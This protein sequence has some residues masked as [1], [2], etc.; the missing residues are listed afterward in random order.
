MMF[1]MPNNDG[2]GMDGA[3]PRMDRAS[4]GAVGRSVVREAIVLAHT[5][6]GAELRLVTDR[7]ELAV[8]RGHDHDVS[9]CDLRQAFLVGTAPGRR[10]CFPAVRD[11]RLGG[12][13]ADV[14]GGLF[15]AW[16]PDLSSVHR[17]FVTSLFPGDIV[18]LAEDWG[19]DGDLPD[20]VV[21]A[22]VAT[23]AAFGLSSVRLSAADGDRRGLLDHVSRRFVE[24]CI[25][26]ELVQHVS[27]EQIPRFS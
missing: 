14:G 22:D 4:R 6:P 25:A 20:D 8:G 2:D 26:E 24:R 18:E 10:D 12:S 11:L 15:E 13:L 27:T 9:P 17:W 21:R 19:D 16:A 1:G 5:V 7:G 23:D 3:S